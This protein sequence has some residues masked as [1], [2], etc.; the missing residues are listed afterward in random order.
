MP[1]MYEKL[2]TFADFCKHFCIKF[3]CKIE[4]WFQHDK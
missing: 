3:I 4:K 1:V 2:H